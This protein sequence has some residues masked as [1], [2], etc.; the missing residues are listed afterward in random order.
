MLSAVKK[1]VFYREDV[2]YPASRRF[3]CFTPEKYEL[4]DLVKFRYIDILKG[5]FIKKFQFTTF[6]P[7]YL[8]LP[9]L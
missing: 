7:A 4:S 6:K 5:I 8:D 9:F 1:L 2:Y 3:T